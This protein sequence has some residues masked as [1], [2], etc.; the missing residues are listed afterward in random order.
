MDKG[1]NI[2]DMAEQNGFG[3]PSDKPFSNGTGS[4]TPAPNKPMIDNENFTEE[5]FSGWVLYTSTK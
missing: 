5:R 3:N 2:L 1:A 4:Y